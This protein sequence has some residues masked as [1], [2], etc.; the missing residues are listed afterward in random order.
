MLRALRECETHSLSWIGIWNNEPLGMGNQVMKSDAGALACYSAILL[1]SFTL[2][3]SVV[4]FPSMT[5]N[6]HDI[7]SNLQTHNDEFK[8]LERE[9]RDNM[10]GLERSGLKRE[11]RQAYEIGTCG[12]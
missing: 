9:V 12:K 8:V 3:L 11:K 5:N 10:R 6:I 2:L 1:S 4:Y 7:Q